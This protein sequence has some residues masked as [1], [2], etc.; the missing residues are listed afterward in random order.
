MDGHHI[1]RVEELTR[2]LLVQVGEDPAREGLLRTPQRVATAWNFL[3]QGYRINLGHLLNDAIFHEECSEL[4]VV[5]DVEFFSL[6][7][8]HLLPFFGRAHVGYLPRGKVIG[9]SKIPRI[10]DMHARRL[11]VQ[12]RLTHQV[13]QTLMHVLE[14]AGVA[15]VMEARHMCMQMR[16][17]EK[18]N[19]YATTSA[20]LGEFHDDQETRAEFM[21]II[22][23]KT[24]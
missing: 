7:E 4:V 21:S 10:I 22:G 9:L 17:V 19:S 13:A 2:E 1:R 24:I 14:P 23:M 3:T 20:M 11:Q 6:C 5:K 18:Q 12:E 8:H 16:G 15:V